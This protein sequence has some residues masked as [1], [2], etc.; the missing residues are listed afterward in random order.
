MQNLAIVGAVGPI[1][2]QNLGPLRLGRHN[3]SKGIEDQ[4]ASVK[5]RQAIARPPESIPLGLW[6]ILI[7][8]CG[9]RECGEE[10][11]VLCHLCHQLAGRE[12]GQ[13]PVPLDD[14]VLCHLLVGVKVH[15]RHRE[16]DERRGHKG[17][18]DNL[19][20]QAPPPGSQ[21]HDDPPT[22]CPS[23][24][25]RSGGRRVPSARPGPGPA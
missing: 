16:Q 25:P 20:S 24:P 14:Q 4:H 2:P 23:G 3:C 8:I 19:G 22:A 18:G 17:P 7:D 15:Q 6:L 11:N 10:V 1:L 5:D 9:A 21:S 13:L 12:T